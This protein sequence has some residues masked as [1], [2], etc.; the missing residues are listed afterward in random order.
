MHGRCVVRAWRCMRQCCAA[1]AGNMPTCVARRNKDF[2]SRANAADDLKCAATR[3]RAFFP[4]T[5][6]PRASHAAHPVRRVAIVIIK[7]EIQVG[8][9]VAEA[10]LRGL[11]IQRN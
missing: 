11:G 2:K 8:L 4:A 5:T 6:A 1:D 9:P 10:R 7:G 3:A